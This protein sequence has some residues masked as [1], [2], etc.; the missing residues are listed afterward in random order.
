MNELRR[1]REREREMLSQ[2]CRTALLLLLLLYIYI[3]CEWPVCFNGYILRIILRTSFAHRATDSWHT[4]KRTTLRRVCVSEWVIV[5]KH[6]R[7]KRARF[8]VD[9]FTLAHTHTLRTRCTFFDRERNS[10]PSSSSSSSPAL[11]FLPLLWLSKSL[12]TRINSWT[13]SIGWRRSRRR[14]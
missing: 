1:E 11:S 4:Q 8:I 7:K 9:T 10:S 5:I 14:G 6:E 3:L 13:N 12:R 2:H